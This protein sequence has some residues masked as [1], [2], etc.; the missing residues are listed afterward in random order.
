MAQ[1]YAGGRLQL[2]LRM[3]MYNVST[4]IW[5]PG[6]LAMG[7]HTKVTTEAAKP[8]TSSLMNYTLNDGY[9]LN[10]VRATQTTVETSNVMQVELTDPTVFTAA[11][12]RNG[13]LEVKSVAQGTQVALERPAPAAGEYLSVDYYHKNITDLVITRQNG[14]TAT[15][16]QATT[17]YALGAYKIPATANG[18]FYQVTV[19][20]RSG[21]TAPTWPTTGGTV[22]DGGVGGVTW[23]DMGTIIAAAETDYVLNSAADGEIAIPDDTRLVAEETLLLDYSYAAHAF[24]LVRLNTKTDFYA[25]VKFDALNTF[26]TT[27]RVAEYWPYCHIVGT[28]NPDKGMANDMTWG[29]TITANAPNL[30]THP[31]LPSDWAEGEVAREISWGA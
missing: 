31:E 4:G 24:D 30:L 12:A 2:S 3:L 5:S 17:A 19:A 18:H 25:A 20:G 6:W 10:A 14:S 22:T 13:L 7:G 29:L 8:T 23:Q 26:R 15:A 28:T 1:R 21:S 16:W 27:R 11:L 9:A